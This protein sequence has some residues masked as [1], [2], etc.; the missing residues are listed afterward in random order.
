MCLGPEIALALQ[1][2]GSVAAVS[3]TAYGVVQGQEAAKASKD[4]ERLRKKQLRLREQQ[5]R[6]KVI[7]EAQL[8]RATS[9]SNIIGQTGTLGGSIFENSAASL[10]AAIGTDLGGISQAANIGAGIF[11]A[12]ARY[13]QASANAQAGS[14]IASFG[15]DL[16]SSGPA[17]GKVGATLFNGQ[18]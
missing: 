15:K 9:A 3:G 12:N 5:D 8:S 17:F 7:R 4:A 16:F 11:D 6:R 18:V 2:A 1:V 10:S 14:G 13:S